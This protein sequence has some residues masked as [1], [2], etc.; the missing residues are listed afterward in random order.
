LPF[1]FERCVVGEIPTGEVGRRGVRIEHLDPVRERAI[2]IGV[3][4]RCWIVLRLD[5]AR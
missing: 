1:R 2:V 5:G 3:G 4:L